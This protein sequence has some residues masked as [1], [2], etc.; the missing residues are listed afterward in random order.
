MR[1]EDG[2]I[3]ELLYF[4]GE[5]DV[6]LWHVGPGG[7]GWNRQSHFGRRLPA[8]A[9]GGKSHGASSKKA[10]PVDPVHPDCSFLRSRTRAPIFSLS[11][12]DFSTVIKAL[13]EPL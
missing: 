8:H 7:L 11:K 5:P 12:L 9:R 1:G 3:Q 4:I 2:G 6:I 10:A 13:M